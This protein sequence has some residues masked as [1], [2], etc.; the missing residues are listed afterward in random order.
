MGNTNGQSSITGK[1]T[2]EERLLGVASVAGSTFDLLGSIKAGKAGKDAAKYRIRAA[3]FYQKAL[4]EQ[5]TQTVG[6][7][8]LQAAQQEGKA[9][10]IAEGQDLALASQGVA[11]SSREAAIQRL[12]SVTLGQMDA[13]AIR[14]GATREAF[15][16][17]SQAQGALAQAYMQ[18]A[19]DVASQEGSILKS[20]L[21]V[22]ESLLNLL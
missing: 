5:A 13:N 12:R 2:F 4:E 17:Q 9:L 18:S 1:K 7:G 10:G 8:G 11:L 19:A 22:A 15:G 16:L 6:A 14:H 3:R 20:G 21:G